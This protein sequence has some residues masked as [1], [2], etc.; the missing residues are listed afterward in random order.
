MTL[1]IN[2]YPIIILTHNKYSP[3]LNHTKTLR[4]KYIW[5]ISPIIDNRL[6]L[7]LFDLATTSWVF[8]IT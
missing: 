8:T 7:T 3:N 6:Y 5:V 2:P 4:Y 1:M